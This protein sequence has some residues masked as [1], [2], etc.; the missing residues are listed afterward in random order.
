MTTLKRVLSCAA[1]LC[2]AV[3]ISV[4]GAD[5]QQP[6]RTKPPDLGP[7]PTFRMPA[8]RHDTL[9]NGLAVVVV[10]KHNVPLVQVNLIVREGFV[11]DPAG[12]PGI[13]SM[14]SAMMME[15]AGTR[16]SLEIADE[17]EYLGARLSVA[18]DPHVTGVRLHIPSARLDAGLA[19]LGDVALRPTFPETELNRKK[20]ERITSLLSWR[21]EA[22]MLASI[23]FYRTLYGTKH[24]YGIPSIG[25]EQSIRAM[26][27]A[28]L[29][30][31][32]ATW[33]VANQATIIVVGDVVL[34]EL[35]GRLERV[36]GGWRKGSVPSV[37]MPPIA[38][39]QGRKVELVDR[40][41]AAQT[42]VRF[43][44]IGVPR[45]TPDYYA[46]TVMNTLLGGSFTSRL[47]QNLREQHGYTYGASS[48]FDFRPYEGPFFAGAAVQ[49]AVTD[50]ALTEFMKELNGIRVLASVSDI[51]RA[52]KYEALGFPGNFQSVGEI[53]GELEELVV[54]G[55]PD[56]YFDNYVNKILA[57]TPAD[58]ERVAKQ[59]VDPANMT[60]VLVGDRK[61]IEAPVKALNLGPMTNL[62]VED[63]LGKAPVP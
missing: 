41:G 6:D 58:V 45:T 3:L 16:G 18:G 55:L 59:Y 61:V 43:G 35:H 37:T 12:S 14:V 24:P 31:F 46:I 44:R 60:I 32:H 27:A 26:T 17:I 15:G 56:D 36:F 19:L 21:D 52:N 10:E 39:V 7:P 63:V 50:K 54:Y 51:E 28:D 8:I 40:P 25:T 23:Q 57:V 20:K 47:N 62:T 5:A 4:A 33:F 34:S 49:T 48:R 29:Q 38:Q 9:S 11:C 1:L 53:A 13:A 2:A 22:R 30:K 42:E